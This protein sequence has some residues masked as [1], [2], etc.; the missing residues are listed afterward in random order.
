MR[1][2]Q[3]S[4]IPDETYSIQDITV[5]NNEGTLYIRTATE[6]YSIMRATQYFMEQQYVVTDGHRLY[7]FTA[8]E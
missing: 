7:V 8:K 4:L 2:I 5:K 6:G 1:I 3:V